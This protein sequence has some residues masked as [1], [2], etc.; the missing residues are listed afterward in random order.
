M[1]FIKFRALLIIGTFP[2]NVRVDYAHSININT[3]IYMLLGK[4]MNLPPSLAGG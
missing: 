2:E 3:Y 1:A 4:G